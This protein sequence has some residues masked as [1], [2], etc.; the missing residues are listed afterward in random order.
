MSETRGGEFSTVRDGRVGQEEIIRGKEAYIEKFLD[1]CSKMKTVNER[2]GGKM[3]DPG[4]I[5][6]S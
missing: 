6:H 5:I 3:T 4:D 2:R 1:K